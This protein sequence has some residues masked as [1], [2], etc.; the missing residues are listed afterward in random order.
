MVID[1]VARSTDGESVRIARDVLCAGAGG[2]GA[3][4]CLPEGP[5]EFARALARRGQ[6]RPVVIGDD[7]A[8]LRVVGLLHRERELAGV[9]VSMVPVGAPAAVA[10]S[11]SLGVPQDTVAAARTVLDG[12]ERA[13]DLLT[14]DSGG[15]VLGGLRI[16][17]GRDGGR[18]GGRRATAGPGRRVFVPGAA[19]PVDAGEPA[20]GVEGAGPSGADGS[21]AVVGADGPRPWWGPA[22]RTARTALA[23]LAPASG[24]WGASRT[25]AGAA[26]GRRVRV[27][28]QRLRIEA[29]G[30]LLA[31]LDR[32]VRGVSVVPGGQ[33]GAGWP[34]AGTGRGEG[35]GD[36]R[37]DGRDGGGE[38]AEVVV[39]WPGGGH[40]VRARA[41]AVTVSGADFHYRADAVVGGPV[42]TRTWTVQ[43]GAWRLQLPRRG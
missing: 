28:G 8:L 25:E 5:E 32:P 4:I 15:I 35:V 33:A 14:D 30:V 18:N 41:R 31:D 42:R 13:M 22:A 6:R 20:A 38:L 1:P 10:L 19:G 12:A 21:P 34:G 36:G 23:L 2:S 24:R 26:G 27:P 9:P 29:D 39:H 37:G 3:K 11:R 40:P 7:R 16:P 43:P 17:C